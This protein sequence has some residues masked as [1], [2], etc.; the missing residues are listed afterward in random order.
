MNTI[1]AGSRSATLATTLEVISKCPWRLSITSVISGTARGADKHGETWANTNNILIKRFPA[2]WNKYGKA[3]GHIR[4]K[5]MADNADSL[6]A[7][8]NGT[9][10]GTESMIK[11][12]KDSGLE[13]FVY[14][15]ALKLYTY[16][17]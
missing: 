12:A 11:Y 7:V 13:L 16:Q 9:S 6:I 17:F 3:A 15:H 14:N 5:L 10:K 2:D 8:W 4:N 1:I